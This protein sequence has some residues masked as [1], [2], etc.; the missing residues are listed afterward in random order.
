MR[1]G[2]CVLIFYLS[3]TTL[4][5]G[6][7]KDTL[8]FKF[9]QIFSPAKKVENVTQL[10]YE[11]KSQGKTILIFILQIE[12]AYKTIAF[13][14]CDYIG[15]KD[16]SWQYISLFGRVRT[17]DHFQRC[18]LAIM[19]LLVWSYKLSISSTNQESSFS[20]S[21]A[22]QLVSYTAFP[23]T[24]VGKPSKESKAPAARI[25]VF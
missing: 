6:I 18:K 16:F 19:M 7:M 4:A 12:K 8:N 3:F 15:N 21:A 13:E 5:R 11:Q 20:T 22:W 25:P 1:P 17:L 23:K 10:K 14:V 24:N 9:K 2:F